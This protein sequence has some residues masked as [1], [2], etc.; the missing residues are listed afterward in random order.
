MAELAAPP[1]RLGI[2]DFLRGVVIVD[3]MLVHYDYLVP[4]GWLRKAINYSDIAMEGF[5]TLAGFMVGYHYLERYRRDRGGA[6]RSLLGR[7]A[8]LYGIHALMVLTISLPLALQFGASVT[9]GDPPWRHVLGLLLLVRQEGLMH[10]LPT[11]IPLFVAAIPMLALL[12]RGHSGLVLAGSVTLFAVGT[13]RPGLLDIGTRA[14][15]PVILWQVY[16]VLGLLAGARIRAGKRPLFREARAHALV[17]AATLVLAAWAYHGHHVAP[18]WDAVRERLHLHVRRFPLSPLGFVY[19]ASLLSLL[20]CTALSL[21]AR[22]ERSGLLQH[23]FGIMGRH[24]LAAFVIHVYFAKAAV[25]V[26]QLGASLQALV[27]GI[28]LAN[29]PATIAILHI[30]ERRAALAASRTAA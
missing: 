18:G 15:F 8:S 11:F 10:I 7:A 30:A 27:L 14:V 26:S 24:S 28:A 17:A 16:F 12:N 19:G 20:V 13:E 9:G 21:R 1:Q 29:V 2:V 6:S 23:T 5:L 22:I 4:L 25:A 3:M